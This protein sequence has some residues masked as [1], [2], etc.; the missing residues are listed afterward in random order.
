MN[1]A[2]CNTCAQ[3]VVILRSVGMV[4]CM[5]NANNAIPERD[6]CSEWRD[7]E[8]QG[9]IRSVRGNAA[10]VQDYTKDA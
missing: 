10:K 6:E 8:V 5:T 9:R 3:C 2:I 1:K 7:R 4:W